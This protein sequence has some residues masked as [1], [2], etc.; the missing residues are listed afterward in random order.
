M[1]TTEMSAREESPSGVGGVRG[2]GLLNCFFS[3]SE[4]AGEELGESG[5]WEAGDGGRGG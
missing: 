5:G 3:S 1:G 4:E 2:Q